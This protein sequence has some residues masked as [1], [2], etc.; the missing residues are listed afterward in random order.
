MATDLGICNSALIKLG[1]GTISTLTENSRQ[2]KI[3]NEQ[4]P[5]MRDALLYDHPWNFAM[6][7][8]ALTTGDTSDT[9]NPEYTYRFTLPADCLRVWSCE[10]D[11]E[12]YEVIDRY[13]YTNDSSVKI[14]YI[15]QVT[16]PSKFTPAFAEALACKI[17]HDNCF[18]LVQSNSLKATL[19][20]EMEKYIPVVR[21]GD[22][23]ENKA[24][25][26]QQDIFINSRY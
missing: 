22:A 14:K 5:K 20:G 3:V 24:K 4:Y 6:A 26:L 13:I 17:A 16:D 2:A 9:N 23:Q 7:W 12:D 18:A 1:V 8:A 25:P 15:K 21:S 11:D 10:F 19:Y